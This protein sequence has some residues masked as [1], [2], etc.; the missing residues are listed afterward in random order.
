MVK[1]RVIAKKRARVRERVRERVRAESEGKGAD[2]GDSCDENDGG[3][4]DVNEND[5]C[6]H[7]GSHQI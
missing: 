1:V 2:N 5:L 6:R 3:D 7:R 4:T